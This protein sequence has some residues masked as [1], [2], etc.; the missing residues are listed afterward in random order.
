MA[1]APWILTAQGNQFN[2]ENLESNTYSIEEIA[3]ALSKTCRF[4]G[5]CKS[6]YSV[7]Q[8]STLCVDMIIEAVAHLGGE[9]DG[10]DY[11][12]T[13]KTVL[14]HDATEAYIGDM[15]RPLKHLPRMSAF[16]EIEDIIH[17]CL[18]SSFG[19]PKV[20]P[21]YQ[22]EITHL[23]DN[24]AL[25]LERKLLLPEHHESWGL[26][27]YPDTHRTFFPLNPS[28]A[29]ELFLSRWP[30]NEKE[31]TLEGQPDKRTGSALKT[32]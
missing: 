26:E 8:H 5:H 15:V 18:R 2:F 9:P 10:F 32:E 7:A 6:F 25:K 27:K 19:L 3:S 1:I 30:I 11:L 21:S 24:M 23:V 14:L 17:M 4:G 16:S 31:F 22:Q 13:Y 29:E 28:E 20:A 12:E